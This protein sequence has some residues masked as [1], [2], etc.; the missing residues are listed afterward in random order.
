MS[1]PLMHFELIA[2]NPNQ[3]KSFYTQLFGWRP[4]E[5]PGMS[6]TL[7]HSD[8]PGAASAAVGSAD[9]GLAPGMTAYAQVDDVDQFLTRARELGAAEVLQEPYDV[10]HVGRF[11]VFRDPEGNRVGLWQLARG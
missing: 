11:A 9:M 2:K 3:L 6:Y 7:L 10:P 1:S 4:E 5:Y 8:A